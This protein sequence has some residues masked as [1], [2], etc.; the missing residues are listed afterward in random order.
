MIDISILVTAGIGFLSTIISGWASWFFARRKY[1]SE[2]DNNLIQNMQE[3]L[4]FYQ[5]LSDDNRVR[6]EDVLKRNAELEKRD[7]ALEEEIKEMK[8]QMFTLVSN[9]CLN[10]SC[11]SRIREKQIKV[12]DNENNIKQKVQES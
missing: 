10:L 2:V 6:L 5:K 9:I 12:E 8:K 4:E 3:S 11:A 7:E 1:N